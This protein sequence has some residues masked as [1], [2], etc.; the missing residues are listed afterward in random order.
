MII[1]SLT[2]PQTQNGTVDKNLK[3]TVVCGAMTAFYTSAELLGG[4]ILACVD[5][6]EEY[7][8]NVR[9]EAEIQFRRDCVLA[10]G[11]SLYDVCAG[12]FDDGE[13]NYKVVNAF[14]TPNEV[15]EY[16]GTHGLKSYAFCVVQKDG[17]EWNIAEFDP[18]V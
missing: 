1:V 7:N 17:K 14:A 9:A 16:V 12:T 10:S 15:L 18:V 13:R 11:N 5:T 8:N 6:Q 3:V 4:G 2:L